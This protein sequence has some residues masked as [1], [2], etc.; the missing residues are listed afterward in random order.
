MNKR[1]EY[2]KEQYYF[3]LNRKGQ[4]SNSMSIPI[5]FMTVIFTACTYFGLNLNDIF[6][7]WTL[8]PFLVLFSVALF[9][10][11]RASKHLIKAFTGLK[12][13][14]N[15][16][17]EKLY[18]FEQKH[19]NDKNLDDKFF[20]GI[21]KSYINTTSINRINNNSR[22]NNLYKTN[23]NTIIAIIFIIISAIP[24]FI[25]KNLNEFN[26]KNRK[27]NFIKNQIIMTTEDDKNLLSSE[28]EDLPSVPDT[29]DFP[30]DEY[31]TE[32]LDI[33]IPTEIHDTI[34]PQVESNESSD[35]IEK[36]D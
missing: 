7:H 22:A 9:F 17:P 2:Y 36:D 18:E 10:I 28:S 30:S 20:E 4:L 35:T 11:F 21:K 23:L 5:G 16:P 8:W 32:S 29:S 6:N 31:V 14:Y 3:E 13:G 27:L 15:P 25:G 26:N 24:F 1:I 12:Y 33:D 19:K 34:P